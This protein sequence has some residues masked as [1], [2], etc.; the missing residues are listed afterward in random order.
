MSV[1]NPKIWTESSITELKCEYLVETVKNNYLKEVTYVHGEHD[2]MVMTRTR[3]QRRFYCLCSSTS[4]TYRICLL[5]TCVI[6]ISPSVLYRNGH[7]VRNSEE[8]CP[9]TSRSQ[10]KLPY[11][12]AKYRFCQKKSIKENTSASQLVKTQM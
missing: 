4:G 11:Q 3:I 2:Y 8:I 10:I 6:A 7:L 12:V 9:L 5:I 1:E